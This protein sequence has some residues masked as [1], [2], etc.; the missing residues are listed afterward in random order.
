MIVL[1]AAGCDDGWHEGD[2]VDRAVTGWRLVPSLDESRFAVTLE[3]RKI[4]R[5]EQGVLT[6]NYETS[7]VGPTVAVENGE[8]YA[9]LEIGATETRVGATRAWLLQTDVT[10]WDHTFPSEAPP[11]AP[12]VRGWLVDRAT[13]AMAAPVVF[14][15]PIDVATLIGD[16][17][18][19]LPRA[20]RSDIARDI[21]L[22]RRTDDGGA[23]LLHSARGFNVATCARADGLAIAYSG[24]D[25]ETHLASARAATDWVVSDVVLTGVAFDPR[26]ATCSDNATHVALFIG[27]GVLVVATD[28]GAPLYQAHGATPPAMLSR[29]GAALVAERADD[30]HLV[31]ATATGMRSLGVV[32]ADAPTQ[33]PVRAGDL[34]MFELE[35]AVAVIDLANGMVGTQVPALDT[36]SMYPYE[37]VALG[38]RFVVQ[39]MTHYEDELVSLVVVDMTSSRSLPL[40]AMR[41][42]PSLQAPARGQIYVKAYDGMDADAMPYL[43]AIDP[44][45]GEQRSGGLLPLCDETMV[46]DERGCR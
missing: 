41:W 2:P 35:L 3:P 22:R 31:H 8:P 45:T 7:L 29:D 30:R 21:V 38:D 32:A 46:L 13:L 37:M 26:F 10:H 11:S 44:T 42:A 12:F 5:N 14:T 39:Q 4:H 33:N 9:E 36:I 6:L 24:E 1:L 19:D 25:G 16:T 23:V 20:G 28:S 34:A 17:L 15:P 27:T 40:P 18:F 43:Y